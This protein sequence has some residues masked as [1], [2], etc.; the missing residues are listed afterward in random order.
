TYA[1]DTMLVRGEGARV[2][3]DAGVRYLDFC[4]GISVC[5]LGHCHPR[6]TAAIQEQAGTLLHV[7]NLYFNDK[8]PKLADKIANHSFGGRVFFCNSGAEANEGLIKFAR[9]W[10]HEEGRFE[11]VA[12]ED[13]FHGRTL[14]TLAA[15]GRAKYRQGFAPDMPGFTFASFNDLASVEEQIGA[16]TVA[17][18]CEPVQGE[19]GIIPA[20]PEFLEGL[21]AL[22]DDRGLLLLFD[23]VQCGMGRT[24][25]MFAHQHYGVIPDGMSMAKALGNGFPMGAFELQEKYNDVLVPGTHASTFGGTPIA[26]AAG[27]AVFE[28]FEEEGILGNAN[29]MAEK[30]WAGLEALAEKHDCIKEVRG[31]GLMIGIDMTTPVKG[32]LAAAKERGLLALSAGETVLRLLPPLTVTAAEVAEA[33][34]ILDQAIANPKD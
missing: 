1:P 5:N 12:M 2:W 17:V 31:L 18:L 20:E 13:S 26:C 24:G 10:G 28:A 19:G 15:T 21:R 8:Q 25:K 29:A 22:C 34:A 30:L 16:E 27:I 32:V 33:L 3:D 23:E 6:V 14:A 9:K 7:S 11:I 4:L